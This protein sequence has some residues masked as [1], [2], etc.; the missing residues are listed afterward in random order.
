[1][2]AARR[3]DARA[4]GELYRRYARMVHGTLLAAVPRLDVDDLVQDVFLAAMRGLDSLHDPA[5]FPAWLAV[6]ARNKAA[7]HFRRRPP[8]SLPLAEGIQ[9]AGD[10]EQA[11]LVL[12]AIRSL[13]RAFNE[14]L[15][16]RLVEGMSG[17]EIAGRTGLTPASVRVNLHRGMKL[18]RARLEGMASRERSRTQRH[19]ASARGRMSAW[20]AS[21]KR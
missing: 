3:G 18:L 10:H 7:D 17:L 5:A 19:A 6:I 15:A 8:D 4:F 16:L 21:K 14:T 12:D 2:E 1:M 11:R 9:A 20:R 13:P